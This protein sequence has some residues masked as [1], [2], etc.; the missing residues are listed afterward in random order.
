MMAQQTYPRINSW[1]GWDTLKEV[2]VGKH[3]DPEYFNTIKSNKVSDPLKRIAEETEDDYQSLIKILK[4]FGVENILRPQFDNTLRF[5]DDKPTHATNPRDYHFVYGNTLY[6]FEDL[7]CYDKLYNTYKDAGEIVFDPYNGQSEKPLSHF[8]EA[9]QCVRF[10]DAILVDR[11]DIKHMRWL[12]EN[13]KDTKIIVSALG[14]HSDGVFCPVK[15]GLIITTY[16]YK[17]HFADTIFKGWEIMCTDNNSWEQTK[18]IVGKIAKMLEKTNNRWY[19]EGEED[20]DELI[21]FIDTYLNEWVGYCAE[22]VFD[23]NM[24]VLDRHNVIVSSYNKNIFDTFKKHK[25]EPIICNFRH[26]Y[27]WDGGLHCNTLDIRREGTKQ[28]YLNY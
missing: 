22:S 6:R 28:R 12:R 16:E 2:W 8:L 11:L 10:G 3:H 25:I 1:C 4:D 24:L 26:R 7:P 23:V 13:I 21:Q 18:P 9:A 17:E 20:N 27:F 5:G 15:P 19:V 14:G